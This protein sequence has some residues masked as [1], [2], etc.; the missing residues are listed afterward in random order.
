MIYLM[1]IFIPFQMA[2][3]FLEVQKQ[4]EDMRNYKQEL[5]EEL[6]Q[7]ELAMEEV[8]AKADTEEAKK[9]LQVQKEKVIWYSC[10]ATA[11]TLNN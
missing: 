2:A 8:A 6:L 5:E 9:F 3:N 11:A 7:S 1:I 10:I 4:L